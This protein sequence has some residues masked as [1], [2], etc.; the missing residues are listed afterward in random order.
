MQSAPLGMVSNLRPM[1]SAG[2]RAKLSV[3]R[4]AV[5]D[6]YE[7]QDKE[8][9]ID[10]PAGTGKTRGVL[11]KLD[12]YARCHAGFRA[13]MLRKTRTSM[14]DTVLV[15]L[16][17]DVL[18]DTL[19]TS[20][21]RGLKRSH[22]DSYDYPN[23]SSLVLG[24]MDK[25]ES[26]MSADYDIIYCGEATELT[27]ED[28]EF[29]LTRLR[30]GGDSTFP[31]KQIICDCNP[32]FPHHWLN[33][34]ANTS[35]MRRFRSVHEDN[36]LWYSDDGKV[37]NAGKD[38]LHDVL[39]RLTG[40]RRKRLLEGKWVAAEGVVYE[41]FDPTFHLVNELPI[42]RIRWFQV[43][44][45]WGYRDP[46]V[47]QVWGVDGDKVMYRACEYYRTEQDIDWWCD[48]AEDIVKEFSPLKRFVCDPSDPG[49][50][51]MLRK[52]MVRYGV[53]VVE[54][55]RAL[56]SLEDRIKPNAPVT[57]RRLIP[58][59]INEVRTRLEVRPDG[60]P[61]LVLVRDALRMPD[62]RL[63][64][65]R[66]PMCA[67]DE[68]VSYMYPK[69]VED[70]KAD[71]IP[72]DMYNHAMDT[73]RYT[74]MNLRSTPEPSLSRLPMTENMGPFGNREYEW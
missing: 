22:R 28:Y 1:I 33:R 14:T 23:G 16:E 32:S 11:H 56:A 48:R 9:L 37:T 41:R 19:G 43:G 8:I 50:I 13:L 31:F 36:P 47:M 51:D 29:A 53:S 73:T 7:C 26:I 20:I 42:D 4:G 40:V 64:V 3:L 66:M 25:R 45:D 57:D 30:P 12:T 58:T 17:R 52:R 70:R 2:V 44:V 15:T 69:K 61:S 71:E 54:A 6:V 21:V 35:E 27:V 72:V 67:E 39:S 55:S 63:R 60:R 65:A 68:F 46:G 10:G 18:A 62:E 38:Y 74:A 5:A 24:G 49:A 34:R 59:G